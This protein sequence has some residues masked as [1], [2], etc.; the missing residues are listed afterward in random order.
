[1]LKISRFSGTI[2]WPI[3]QNLALCT[4]IYYISGPYLFSAQT[5]RS[6][7]K[8]AKTNRAKYE[9]ALAGWRIFSSKIR[10]AIQMDPTQHC[11]SL[12][13]SRLPSDNSP[14]SCSAGNIYLWPAPTTARQTIFNL[15]NFARIS[16]APPTQLSSLSVFLSL[17]FVQLSCKSGWIVE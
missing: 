2:Q 6:P 8:K 10:V 17:S 3:K 11:V 12:C 15:N 7:E 14:P 5:N 1:M 16:W 13:S 9:R 4:Y